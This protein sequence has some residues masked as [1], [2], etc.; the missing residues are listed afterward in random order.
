MPDSVALMV[1]LGASLAGLLLF[2]F[3]GWITFKMVSLGFVYLVR[4]IEALY[5]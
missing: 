1:V 2:G 5:V 4:R 3:A